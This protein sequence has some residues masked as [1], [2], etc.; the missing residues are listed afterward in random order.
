MKTM[1]FTILMVMAV[2][3]GAWAVTIY[4]S[5]STT[6]EPQVDYGIY[7]GNPV[8]FKVDIDGTIYIH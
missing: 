6:A 8:A 3:A 7:N 2:S 1:I 5:S 4:Q